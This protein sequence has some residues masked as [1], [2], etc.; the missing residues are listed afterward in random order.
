MMVRSLK[1]EE[2]MDAMTTTYLISFPSAALVTADKDPQADSVAPH[3]FV[4]EAK[5]DASL[6]PL[7]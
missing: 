1:R 7:T 6:K 2:G 3:A 4:Q 5:D